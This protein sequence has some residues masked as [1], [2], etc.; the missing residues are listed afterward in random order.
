M[1][2]T[3]LLILVLL[4][5]ALRWLRWRRLATTCLVVALAA[6]LAIGC[7]PVPRLLLAHLQD[8]YPTGH[9]DWGQRNAIILL[10]SGSYR[11]DAGR[12]T[13]SLFANARLLR[14][15]MLYRAC[16]ATGADCR[17]E[18]S[19]GDAARHGTPEAT[20]YGE[21]LQRLGVP[22]SDLLL[23]R[24]SMN[25]WQNAQFSAPLLR[26][27]GAD[28]VLL[29][30]SGTHLRRADLYFRHFGV[31][32]TPVRAD[33]LAASLAWLPQAWN[34]AVTDLALHEYIGIARYYVYEAMGWNAP[35][36]QPATA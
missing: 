5:I 27:Y 6:V 21:A 9:A 35:A 12:A 31:H 7:G 18:A 20:L 2:L 11:D 14:A 3:V 26:D 23:E 33:Y 19:G 13:P 17:V 29:V 36:V 1:T 16:K 15:A 32:A 30:S 4:G 10:G 24:R 25:T 8:G 22:A 34:L 28:R